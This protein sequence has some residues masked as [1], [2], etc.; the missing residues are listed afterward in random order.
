MERR[1]LP[2]DVDDDYHY[3]QSLTAAARKKYG[4]Q[5]ALIAVTSEQAQLRKIKQACLAFTKGAAFSMEG[6]CRCHV[7]AAVQSNLPKN[8]LSLLETHFTQD[9]LTALSKRNST[10]DKREKACYQ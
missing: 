7:D 4:Y 5:P 10:Y 1:S 8:D 9:T 3:Q 2:P 6:F